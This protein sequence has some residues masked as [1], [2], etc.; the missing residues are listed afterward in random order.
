V[1]DPVLHEAFVLW[2]AWQTIVEYVS[3]EDAKTAEPQSVYGA[4]CAVDQDR[5][6]ALLYA[7]A[8]ADSAEDARD[9][10]ADVLLMARDGVRPR[11]GRELGFTREMFE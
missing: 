4:A 2:P 1:T 9:L 6:A 5:L 11:Y 7:H 3:R 8:V 10:L